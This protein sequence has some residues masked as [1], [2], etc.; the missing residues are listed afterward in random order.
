M[1]AAAKHYEVPKSRTA[2]IRVMKQHGTRRFELDDW[3]SSRFFG[4]DY[5]WFWNR[6]FPGR[7]RI[8]IRE[9]VPM[10]NHYHRHWLPVVQ[11]VEAVL[12]K[13]GVIH[14]DHYGAYD[15]KQPQSWL[16][17]KY[18]GA[19]GAPGKMAQL[20]S[21][22]ELLQV[23]EKNGRVR[24]HWKE[25]REYKACPP[26]LNSFSNR[27]FPDRTELRMAELI[28]FVQYNNNYWDD[29]VKVVVMA[30]QSRGIVIRGSWRRSWMHVP[31]QNLPFRYGGI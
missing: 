3:Q 27:Y 5:R 26:G 1:A 21:R 4:T 19:C 16:P 14:P 29:V 7:R 6:Y 23:M 25:A 10:V 13:R 28:P 15:Y 18:I 31:A 2:L 12:R 20:R 11:L 22:A 30:L 24:I 9:L 8:M 17:R